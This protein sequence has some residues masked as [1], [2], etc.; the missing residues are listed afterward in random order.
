MAV[1]AGDRSSRELSVKPERD[2]LVCAVREAGVLCWAGGCGTGDPVLRWA[3]RIACAPAKGEAVAV[4]GVHG[5]HGFVRHRR[6][7]LLSIHGTA[8]VA[9]IHSGEPLAGD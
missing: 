9:G 7:E 5:G 3:I 6:G 1:A 2:G 4:A 8:N